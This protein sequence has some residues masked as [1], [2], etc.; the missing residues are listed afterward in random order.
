VAGPNIGCGSSREH[1]PWG[2]LDYGFEAVVSSQ[3]A[4]IFKNNCLKNGLL[5]VV[6]DEATHQTLL[7][8]PGA[9]VV[10]DVAHRTLSIVGGPSTTFAL[11]PFAQYCLLNGIDEAGYLLS[12]ADA[13]RAYEQRMGL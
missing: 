11:E 10:I 2:L 8:S 1:A 4:D 12:K 3:I 13:I 9:E 5:P 7:H 6:V